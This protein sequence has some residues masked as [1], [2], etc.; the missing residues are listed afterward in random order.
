M[1]LTK[2]ARCLAVA[3]ILTASVLPAADEGYDN[4]GRAGFGAF[5]TPPTLE[6]LANLNLTPGDGGIVRRVR[7]GSTAESLGIQPGDVVRSINDAPI[8]SFRDVRALVRTVAPGD[9]VRVVVTTSNGTTEVLDGTFKVRQPRPSGM[10]PW[11][12]GMPPWAMNGG[13]PPWQSPEDVISEQRQ[14]LIDEK[15]RLDVIATEL[16][17]ARSTLDAVQGNEAWYCTISIEQE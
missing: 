9:D 7:P 14:Q 2:F 3:G 11:G 4:E 5:V 8:Q 15:Q 16:H 17:A 10:P 1:N 6:E 12:N 13:Q